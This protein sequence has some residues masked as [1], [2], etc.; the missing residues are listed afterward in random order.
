M[1]L[2]D[3]LDPSDF[4]S[5]ID[6]TSATLPTLGSTHTLPIYIANEGGASDSYLLNAE[7]SWDEATTMWNTAIP[8]GWTVVFKHA[9]VD[10][11]R[12]GTIDPTDIQGTGAVLSETPSIPGG[13]VMF[14]QMEVTIPSDPTKAKA[15]SD[16]ED[17]VN[18][19]FTG[20]GGD[21]D[22]DYII[23]VVAK[24]TTSGA[25][26]RKVEGID[27]ET[28]SSLNITPPAGANQIE[29]NG[30]MTYNHTLINS[31]N[32]TEP[33]D[34]TTGDNQTGF[35]S[36]ID[37]DT[38]GVDGPDTSLENLCSLNLTT[39]QVEQN[40]G[41]IATI[42]VACD[43]PTD[44]T[45]IL[46]LDP[47]E[48]LPFEVKV[49]APNA[50]EGQI[51]TTTITAVTNT[52]AGGT[53]GVTAEGKD[54]SE[55]ATGQV[56]LKKYADIDT[57]C[58]GTPDAVQTFQTAHTTKVEP[59]EC[60]IWKL[61]AMNEGSQDAMN[62][63]I[64]DQRTNFTV[65][66]DSGTTINSI[67]PSI[68][69]GGIVACRNLNVADSAT[70]VTVTDPNHPIADAAE[71]IAIGEICVPSATTGADITKGIVANDVTFDIG[72]L[73]PGDKAVGHFVVQVQ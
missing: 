51:N 29:P 50:P 65:F 31:G 45:P 8:D 2:P 62:T 59:G 52:G 57:D 56:R 27:V 26:D 67:T 47:G 35:T 23:S 20:V 61:I 1:T 41:S 15:E 12:D 34:L 53:A 22:L 60:V 43:S 4:A 54:N 13:S 6:N 49:T 39:I 3:G 71:R 5:V 33:V 63:I 73:I 11:G 9:G 10:L 46:T 36:I 21:D 37:I 24:S 64:R 7:G 48:E 55:V 17:A 14:V 32:T 38:D 68:T 66:A 42:D 44:T 30:T 16:Q 69:N 25:I 18:A 58:D 72:E 19:N 28:T 70:I 40:D